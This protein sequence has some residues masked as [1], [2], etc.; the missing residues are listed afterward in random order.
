VAVVLSVWSGIAFGLT[1][2]FVSFYFVFDGLSRT[3]VDFTGQEAC[4]APPHA[5]CVWTAALGA[6]PASTVNGSSSAPAASCKFPDFETVYCPQYTTQ[7]SCKEVPA[8]VFNFGADACEHAVGMLPWQAGLF[9]TGQPAGAAVASFVANFA[10][11]RSTFRPLLWISALMFFGAAV[12]LHV[13]RAVD[14]FGVIIAGRLLSGAAVAMN[15]Q[16]VAVLPFSLLGPGRTAGLVTSVLQPFTELGILLVA[17]FTFFSVPRDTAAD[18][19]IEGIVHGC[20]G[21]M[22]V[23]AFAVAVTTLFLREPPLPE[24]Q[25]GSVP[26]PPGGLFLPLLKFPGKLVL[27]VVMP[28]AFVGT[29]L[30][31]I[32]IFGPLYSEEVWGIA[33]SLIPLVMQAFSAGAGLLS[34]ALRRCLP[35]PRPVFLAGLVGATLSSLAFAICISPGVGAAEATRHA[36]ALAFSALFFLALQGFVGSALFELALTL[37]PPKVRAG[38]GAFLNTAFN[39]V[40]TALNFVFPIAVFGFSGGPSGNVLQGLSITYFIFAAIGVVCAAVLAKW[41][42]PVSQNGDGDESG[43]STA[44]AAEGGSKHHSTELSVGPHHTDDT[45]HSRPNTPM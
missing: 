38:G 7:D 28:L 8:C 11:D 29:G 17:V 5:N 20:I 31:G 43:A 25:R 6:Q 32:G 18:G 26:L 42:I 19:N 40:A 37:L 33:P 24:G 41:M 16:L 13:G 1:I 2:G 3:C 12:L 45:A 15:R 14:V 39:V 44:A 10:L 22:H 4:E 34:F 27:L 23:L 9:A 35:R 36:T 30:V 21:M